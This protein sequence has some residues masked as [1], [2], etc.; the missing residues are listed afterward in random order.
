MM[1]G[2]NLAVTQAG[3]SEE[4]Y[5]EIST[6]NLIAN[7]ET[8]IVWLAFKWF[9]LNEIAVYAPDKNYLDWFLQMVSWDGS[10]YHDPNLDSVEGEGAIGVFGSAAVIKGNMFLLKNQP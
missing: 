6:S 5:Y 9:G 1:V 2:G 8:P 4:Y 3:G 7:T 10:S